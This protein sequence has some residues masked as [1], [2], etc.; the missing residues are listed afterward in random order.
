MS[1][2]ASGLFSVVDFIFNK[3]NVKRGPLRSYSLVGGT[4]LTLPL[5]FDASLA[6]QPSAARSF[7]VDLVRLQLLRRLTAQGSSAGLH[8]AAAAGES[9]V[10]VEYKVQ[11]VSGRILTERGVA[12]VCGV[13][14][15]RSSSSSTQLSA[16]CAH[17]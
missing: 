2:S 11:D 10:D 6:V 12:C 5:T 13:S 9:D 4:G 16:M 3:Y 1:E 17:K 7:A 14:N 15:A 8:F